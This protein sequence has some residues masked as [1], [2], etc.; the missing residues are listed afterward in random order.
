LRGDQAGGAAGAGSSYSGPVV[1]V[2]RGNTITVVPVG[3]R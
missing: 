2:A 3:A 1:R